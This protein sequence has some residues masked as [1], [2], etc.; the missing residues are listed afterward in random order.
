MPAA[1]RNF[2]AEA[3]RLRAWFAANRHL[4]SGNGQWFAGGEPNTLDPAFFD[5]ARVRVLIVR[6]SEYSE[7]AAGITHSYLYQMAAAVPG[8]YVDL[9]FLPPEADEK[10]MLAGRVPLLTGTGSKMPAAAFDIVAISNSVL[11]ELINLPAMLHNAGLPL[12][13]QARAVAGS[14]L[15]ILGG[16][17]S[18]VH[19]ILHG[20][21][22]DNGDAGLVDAVIM[23]DGE[24]VMARTI[25]LVRDHKESGRS[26]LLALLRQGVSGFFDPEVFSETYDAVGNL[27]RLEARAGTVTPIMVSKSACRQG[28]ETFTGGPLLY[29]GSGT[30]HVIV[31]AGCPSFCSFCKESWEQKPYRENAADKVMAAA[32]SLKASMGLH[33]ISLMTFNANT[34]SDIYFLVERLG[35][36]FERVAI[37]SQRFDAVVNSPELL[38]MQFEAGKRTYTCAMEGISERLRAMLQKNLD[39]KTILSGFD[40][41]LQRNMRQMKVFLIVT[42]Y[43][44]QADLDEFK[45]FLEMVKTRCNA[46]NSRPRLTFSFATLFRA[47]QTPMQYAAVRG[48]EPALKKLLNTLVAIVA[49]SGFE[50][51]ISSG[52][53]DAMVSEYIA[54]A[55]RRHTSLLVEAS[56]SR[57]FR[58]RGS[59]SGKV[60]EYWRAALR[61]AGLVSLIDRP[62]NLQT[63]MPW[64]N[65]DTG[66]SKNFLWQT[67]QNLEKGQQIRACLATPWGD[68]RCS[69]CGACAAPE[70]IA[71]LTRMGPETSGRLRPAAPQARQGFWLL[72]NIPEKWAFCSREFI[73]AALARRLM[74]DFP[75]MV[76]AFLCVESVEPDFFCYGQAMAKVIANR[77]P[78]ID[79]SGL[80]TV[81]SPDDISIIK[82]IRPTG[83]AGEDVF[84]VILDAAGSV[85]AVD[86]AMGREIDALLTRYNLKNQKQ[87]QNGWLNWQVAAGQARKAGI[88]KISLEEAT[89]RLRLVLVRWPELFI[90]NRLAVGR[91]FR[92]T[93]PGQQG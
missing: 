32:R 66:I 56:I 46:T 69:G 39:E 42:G 5:S 37:K 79:F 58:Y 3:E 82:M 64:D 8:C 54:F 40:L 20:S 49:D 80:S 7:V 68:G 84:P 76:D 75:A 33:E 57:G 91:S 52:P 93:L 77:A 18:S 14:P 78:E 51:R 28:S 90:L 73:K 61:K 62:R 6:L 67:W 89:G 63:V 27:E 17:N 15:V 72:F 24:G 9:A 70:E 11:Q 19:A 25:E 60:L 36:M 23:G 87:R 16:S 50:A 83:K 38:D 44:Q 12:T 81:C 71:R 4:M 35:T 45:A 85:D 59:V 2:T 34:C 13:R 92:V 48:G 29:D 65:V 21:V 74:L 88:E 30:S 10:L 22:A 53:E 1:A 41:L 55:D 47:P 26:E 86:P 43:E 31:S